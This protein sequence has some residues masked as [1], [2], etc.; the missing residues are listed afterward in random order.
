[1]WVKNIEHRIHPMLARNSL[2]VE[3]G[4]ANIANHRMHFVLDRKE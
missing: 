3:R 1:V 4:I 2:N